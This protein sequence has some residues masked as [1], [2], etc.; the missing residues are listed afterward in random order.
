VRRTVPVEHTGQH[1]IA[2]PD[3]PPDKYD[4]YTVVGL[5]PQDIP[6]EASPRM[7]NF[8]RAHGNVVGLTEES[9]P[10]FIAEVRNRYASEEM[11]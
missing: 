9:L 6:A 2:N 1:I 7:V 8:V 10:A 11:P 3:D 5:R 4:N